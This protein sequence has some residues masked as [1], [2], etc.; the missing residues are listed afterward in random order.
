MLGML[1]AILS[2][3][4]LRLK[5][6]WVCNGFKCWP[7]RRSVGWY[8]LFECGLHVAVKTHQDVPGRRLERR[9]CRDS[10]LGE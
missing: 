5:K 2:V 1:W 3:V 7:E 4:F 6:M 10:G 9:H 8:A